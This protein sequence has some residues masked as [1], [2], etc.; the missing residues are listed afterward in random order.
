MRCECVLLVRVVRGGY[1]AEFAVACLASSLTFSRGVVRATLKNT[2]TERERERE[3][4]ERPAHYQVKIDIQTEKKTGTEICHSLV[5]VFVSDCSVLGERSL[6]HRVE[7][8]HQRQQLTHRVA[9]IVLQCRR[10][11]EDRT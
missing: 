4:R 9:R 10:L 3:R 2:L 8:N 11:G 1:Y 6:Q 7:S 5:R